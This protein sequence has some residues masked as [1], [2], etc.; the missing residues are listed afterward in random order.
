MTTDI[1]K[2]DDIDVMRLGQVLA[3]SGYFQDARD[4]AQAVVKVLAGRELGFGPIASMTGFHIVK[5]KVS[6]SANLMAAAIKRSGRYD[7]R[8]AELTPK[9]CRLAFTDKGE[10]I[11]ESSFTIEEATAAGLLSNA[12]W[13]AYPRN[14]LFARALS[15]GAKWYCPDIF[16]GPVYTPEELGVAVDGEG[17]P[18]KPVETAPNTAVK[19]DMATGEVIEPDERA[20]MLAEVSEL[21]GVLGMTD[22]QRKNAWIEYVGKGVKA[23]QADTGKLGELVGS[24]RR[25]VK[26]LEAPEGEAEGEAA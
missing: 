10:P 15:N 23:Q 25:R 16:G 18:V 9:A 8:V 1:A 5:G 14:M 17:E 24:L 22:E 19:V 3:R 13:K 26:A 4:M 6:M 7:Y 20:A 2:R 11:G 21:A 12:T